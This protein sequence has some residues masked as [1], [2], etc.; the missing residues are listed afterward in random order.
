MSQFIKQAFYKQ[1][2]DFQKDLPARDKKYTLCSGVT[3]LEGHS[4]CRG[5][6]ACP[7]AGSVPAGKCSRSETSRDL[8]RARRWTVTWL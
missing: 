2:A 6:A 4:L 5:R 3:E 8:K 7:Q 1:R